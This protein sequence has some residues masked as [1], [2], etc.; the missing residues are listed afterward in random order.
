MSQGSVSELLSKPKPWHMLSIKGREPF[1]RMQLWLNDPNSIE[2]LQTLKNERREANKRR[3]THMEDGFTF[4][5]YD[6]PLFNMPNNFN[7]TSSLSKNILGNQFASSNLSQQPAVKKARILFTEEQKEALKIAFAMD[8]YPSSTTAEFLAKE[9]NLSI[10]TITNWFHNHRM[11]LKQINTSVG[12]DENPINFNIGR[13]NVSFD[14]TNFRKA[15]AERLAAL[16]LRPNNLKSS[17]SSSDSSANYGANASPQHFK[18]SSS[19][20]SS[21]YYSTNSLSSPGSSSPYHDEEETGTLDLSMAS[22]NPLNAESD[23]LDSV[24]RSSVQDDYDDGCQSNEEMDDDNQSDKEHTV[25]N[26]LSHRKMFGSSRRKPQHV[27]SSSS[28][29][30]AAQPQQWLDQHSENGYSD[31]DYTE[32]KLSDDDLDKAKQLY[33]ALDKNLELIKNNFLI[34][35]KKRPINDVKSDDDETNDVGNRTDN[36]ADSD[37]EN[38]AAAHK[39]FK[40]LKKSSSSVM[41]KISE[42][43]SNLM[44]ECA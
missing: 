12:G 25:T 1:I 27:M 18:Y 3:R 26:H 42:D 10:R 35:N 20:H 15:L 30:K 41:S 40:Q 5:Q 34:N 32:N 8:P 33:E 28:R 22:H 6:N 11:R 14:Q 16:K 44:Q 31:E 9:L 24:G 43:S 37:L 23:K 38:G 29:R 4:K 36:G 21:L 13:D 17:N 7:L 19:M 39:S 2:K